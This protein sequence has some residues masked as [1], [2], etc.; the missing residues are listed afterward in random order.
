MRSR[1]GLSRIKGG[2]LFSLWWNFCAENVFAVREYCSGNFARFTR[3]HSS[4]ENDVK[5]RCIYAEIFSPK[6]GRCAGNESPFIQKGCVLL[7]KGLACSQI[8]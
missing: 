6:V 1:N 2:T 5:R 4:C 7:E 8:F 3:Y